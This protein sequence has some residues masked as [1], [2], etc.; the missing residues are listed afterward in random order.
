LTLA[1]TGQTRAQ[2]PTLT[3]TPAPSPSPTATPAPSPTVQPNVEDKQ[4]VQ[5]ENLNGVPNVAPNYQQDDKSLPDLGRVGVDMLEQKPLSLKE[6]ITLALENNKDIEVTRQNVRIA[7][8]EL[9]SARGFYEPR[10]SGQTYYERAK[11]PVF[12]FFGGGPDGSLTTSSIVGNAGLEGSIRQ[13]GGRFSVLADSSRGTT[14]N[15]FSLVNPTYTTNLRFQFTQPIFRGRSFD[16]PR[17]NIEIAKRNL[18][19]TDTQFRQRSIEIIANVQRA[20]WDLVYSLRNLQVQRDGVRDAKEQLEHNRRL[21]E[22]GQLAPIDIVA[23]ETQVANIEQG[24]Y[25]ALETVSRAENT[26]KNLVAQ[27]KNDRL[28]SESIVPT[29]SVDLNAPQTNF[30]EALNLALENRPEIDINDVQKDINSLEQRFNREQTKPQIDLIANYSLTGAA[31]TLNPTAINPISSQT[32]PTLNQVIR[33]INLL[34]AQVNP[35]L[36]QIDEIPITPTPTLPDNL[37][38]G[39]GGALGNLFAN[40]YPTLRVGV[41]FNLPL[42]GDKTARA[43]LGRSLVQGE[44]IQTQRAQIEQ[45]IQVDVRNA[46]QSIRTAEA[47]LRSAAISRENSQKQYE[48]EQRK[49]DA[50]QSDVYKVLERQTALINARSNELRAQTELNK[51]IA[52][53]QRATGNSL[54]ANNVEARLRK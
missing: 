23:A 14:N 19:L 29:D 48:S 36:P 25:E 41:Q 16:Q 10:F 28:W 6:A 43:N 20:Y 38:G 49:L 21:V 11:T 50:G 30:E 46:L 12:S 35:P 24:V 5:P 47:R 1:A 2:E 51:A 4:K 17:R 33:N 31:G 8:F 22:E 32:T 15:L 34:S 9:Q 37:I 54:K 53:L 7:E 18:S 40:R 39:A 52:D 42:F 26:L 44:Q 13:T 27:N 3:P 45:N